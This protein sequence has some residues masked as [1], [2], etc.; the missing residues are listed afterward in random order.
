MKRFLIGQRVRVKDRRLSIYKQKGRVC[1]MSLSD[2]ERSAWVEMDGELPADLRRLPIEHDNARWV[3][4]HASQC[5]PLRED[6]AR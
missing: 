4:L 3:W 1:Q 6:R 5:G 2:P